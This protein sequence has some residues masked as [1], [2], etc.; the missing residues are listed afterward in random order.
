MV[1]Q[2]RPFVKTINKIGNGNVSKRQL[3]DQKAEN[4][5]LMGLQHSE[6]KSHTQRQV[7]GRNTKFRNRLSDRCVVK[8]YKKELLGIELK[9][10]PSA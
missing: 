6:N 2:E 7:S 4:R 3:P 9:N 8:I 5:S 1:V 10:L